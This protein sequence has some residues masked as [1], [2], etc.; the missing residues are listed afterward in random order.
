MGLMRKKP[1]KC[2]II[3]HFSPG[4]PT[5]TQKVSAV[6]RQRCVL[7]SLHTTS[8]YLLRAGNRTWIKDHKSKIKNYLV[9]RKQALGVI[10]LYLLL[11]CS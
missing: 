4:V 8:V 3:P 5:L 11:M 2:V 10:C 6:Q 7:F 9:N 1:E